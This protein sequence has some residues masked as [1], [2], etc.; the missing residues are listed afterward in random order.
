M[1]QSLCW[2]KCPF[3]IEMVHSVKNYQKMILPSEKLI[4]KEKTNKER[5]AFLSWVG[6]IKVR[7]KDEERNMRV[8]DKDPM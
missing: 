5:K 7:K 1:C 2:D 8:R 4:T 6:K 3:G